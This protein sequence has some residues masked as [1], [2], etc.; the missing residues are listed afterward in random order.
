MVDFAAEDEEVYCKMLRWFPDKCPNL[1]CQRVESLV[2][3]MFA[4]LMMEGEC[5]GDPLSPISK[6]YNPFFNLAEPIIFNVFISC[7]LQDIL[8]KIME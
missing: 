7:I 5:E 6:W 4:L 8:E 1:K 3:F 2:W